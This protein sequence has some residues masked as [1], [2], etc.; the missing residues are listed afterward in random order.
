[1]NMMEA[2][3]F[4]RWLLLALVLTVLPLSSTMLAQEA[5]TETF[6]T[7][8]GAFTFDYPDGWFVEDAG[9]NGL[10]LANSAE[11]ID[12]VFS[13]APEPGVLVMIFAPSAAVMQGAPDG[14]TPESSPEEV[15]N[16]LHADLLGDLNP[17]DGDELSEVTQVVLNDRRA[18]RFDGFAGA[19][20]VAIVVLAHDTGESVSILIAY[21]VRDEIAEFEPTLL[22]IAETM[23]T[24]PPSD[25]PAI[26]SISPQGGAIAYGDVVEAVLR[27][28][29]GDRY[30]FEGAEGDIVTIRMEGDFDTYL[31][32]YDPNDSML[33]SDDDSG[34]DLNS[35]IDSFV[36]PE[37]GT[38]AIVARPLSGDGSGTYT[39]TLSVFDVSSLRQP[40]PI[41][42]GE[43]VMAELNGITGDIWTFVGSEGD[44]IQIEMVADFDNYLEL[45]NEDN[46]QLITDDDSAGNGNA[47]IV[48][49]L[50]ADGTYSILARSY[51]SGTKGLYTLTLSMLTIVNRG[52]L[53]YGD[54]VRTEIANAL[55]DHWTFMGEEGD[56]ISIAMFA[57]YDTDLQLFDADNNQIAQDTEYVSYNSSLL[58]GITLPA[59]GVYTIVAKGSGGFAGPYVLM[60]GRKVEVDE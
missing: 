26:G 46:D 52:A 21:T 51:S 11:A 56:V 28:G 29:D 40:G 27:S 42:I 44:A 32:L 55:G 17:A 35:L 24:M 60:V 16:L 54:I 20:G 34:G 15:A 22:A 31:E 47:R 18:Y 5:L 43:S 7:A 36:L 49:T 12:T 38:Y 50:P 41:A 33:T 23:Q 3:R 45:F 37:D 59:E 14:I 19:Q 30:T 39:L 13:G 10:Y 1:M 9:M 53:T 4:F 2:R 48:Y 57:D 25:T 8:D 6:T 58:D